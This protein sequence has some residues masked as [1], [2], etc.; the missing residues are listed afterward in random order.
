MGKH[1]IHLNAD[2][3]GECWR[4]AHRVTGADPAAM[5]ILLAACAL[6]ARESLMELIHPEDQ[7]RV[8][9]EVHNYAQQ[10]VR[11][12]LEAGKASEN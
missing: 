12:L 4:K 3:V 8:D 9:D 6:L 10:I 1:E 5:Y 2:Q 7:G 11:D